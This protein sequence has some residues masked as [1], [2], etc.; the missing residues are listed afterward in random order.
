MPSPSG[1]SRDGARAT[2]IRS[3]KSTWNFGTWMIL[4]RSPVAEGRRIP[5][6]LSGTSSRS[7]FAMWPLFPRP[8]LGR[9]S[10][11]RADTSVG[12]APNGRRGRTGAITVHLPAAL[13]SRRFTLDNYNNCPL[14]W[15]PR[16]LRAFPRG[17]ANA[18][19]NS[20][21]ARSGTPAP[22]LGTVDLQVVQN[23]ID[24]AASG[25]AVLAHRPCQHLPNFLLAHPTALDQSDHHGQIAD[26]VGIEAHPL[27][28]PGPP[29]PAG[30]LA[31]LAV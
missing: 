25:D 23:V 31:A 10:W 22:V 19:P 24:P 2:R 28:F 7:C 13:P 8:F 21:R 1:R 26:D 30:A 27:A 20:A 29:A 12:A 3:A 14:R 11:T 6:I 18:S 4:R 9:L 16:A 5:S 15:R 17:S